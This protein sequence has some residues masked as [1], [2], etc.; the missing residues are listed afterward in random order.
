MIKKLNFDNF[1]NYDISGF[2]I[3]FKPKGG[4]LHRLYKIPEQREN[5]KLI[6][7]EQ[8]L[9]TICTRNFKGVWYFNIVD[10]ETEEE[11]HNIFLLMDL[12]PLFVTLEE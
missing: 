2:L 11:I 7:I 10:I 9:N 1:K 3:F 12:H 8:V 6:E 5:Y 4:K